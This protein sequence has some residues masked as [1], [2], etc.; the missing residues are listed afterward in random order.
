M[1]VK[2]LVIWKEHLTLSEDSLTK[3]EPE[4]VFSLVFSLASSWGIVWVM[5]SVCLSDYWSMH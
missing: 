3:L 1:T 2:H 5:Q 4:L